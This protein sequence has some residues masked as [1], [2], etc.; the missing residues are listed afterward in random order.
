MPQV[1]EAQRRPPDGTSGLVPG[2]VE[3]RPPEGLAQ[4]SGEDQSV[5]PRRRVPE[6][7]SL[8]GL[9]DDRRQVNDPPAGVS[10]RRRDDPVTGPQLDRLGL[11]PRDADD[12]VDVA[13]TEG[14]QLTQPEAPEPGQ[15]DEGPVAVL[16]GDGEVDTT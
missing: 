16:D 11:D 13:S 8:E 14:E 3:G 2:L 5:G 6:Q 9:R 1:V 15:Q 7:V 12:Q 10:L 4:R